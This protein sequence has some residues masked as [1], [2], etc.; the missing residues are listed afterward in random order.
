M[1]PRDVLPGRDYGEQIIEA[2]E[3]AAVT[4]LVLSEH[5][6]ASRH[7]RNEIERA[8][9]KA[10]AV[11]PVRIREVLPSKALELF[12]SSSAPPACRGL[13]FGRARISRP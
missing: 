8:V 12:V 9:A 10:K 2:I 3:A 13:Q 6:N 4:L 5:A 1:A 11:L 7:V